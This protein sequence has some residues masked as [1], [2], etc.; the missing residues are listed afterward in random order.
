MLGLVV[1]WW[2]S[3]AFSV[4]IVE[5]TSDW[6]RCVMGNLVQMIGEGATRWDEIVKAL[7]GVIDNVGVCHII[8]HGG[9][10]I[11]RNSL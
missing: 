11:S 7:I 2:R 8:G 9:A 1:K 3:K 10:L 5:V 6:G 4:E